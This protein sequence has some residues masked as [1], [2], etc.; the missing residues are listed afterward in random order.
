[1]VCEKQVW[2]FVSLELCKQKKKVGRKGKYKRRKEEVRKSKEVVLKN[3]VKKEC[4][5]EKKIQNGKLLLRKRKR[6]GEK[7]GKKI[8]KKRVVL[9]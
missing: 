3:K 7:G 4:P 1:M 5:K 8:P 6:K 9:E 2:G